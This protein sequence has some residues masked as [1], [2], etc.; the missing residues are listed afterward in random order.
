MGEDICKQG[1]RQG[2][3]LQNTNN[4]Y[5]PAKKKAN[6]PIEKWEKT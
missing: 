2:L 1:D 4:S 3:N 6:N 5:N